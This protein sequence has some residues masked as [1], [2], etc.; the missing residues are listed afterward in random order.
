MT[1]GYQIYS[2]LI[3]LKFESSRDLNLFDVYFACKIINEK[4]N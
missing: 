2:Y 3:L 1:S 4:D